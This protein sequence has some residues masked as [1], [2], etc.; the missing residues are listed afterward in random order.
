MSIGFTRER[1]IKKDWAKVEQIN[2][3]LERLESL[4]KSEIKRE[5]LLAQSKLVWKVEVFKQAII[6]RIVMLGAGCTEAW[7]ARNFLSAI[8]CMRATVETCAFIIDI[9]KQLQK[10]CKS[11]DFESINNLLAK[12]TFG[13]RQK[14]WLKNNENDIDIEAVQVLN[15]ID[16]LDKTF[17]KEK[18][19]VR[20]HYDA[21][22]D[23]CHPN[24]LGLLHSFGVIDKTTGTVTFS[25][26]VADQEHTL[27]HILAGMNLVL[28]AEVSVNNIEKLIPSILE[29]SNLQKLVVDSNI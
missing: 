9:E 25:D 5:G 13:T 6:H 2:K 7:N 17:D 22:S 26:S 28:F 27:N 15:C 20:T 11:S 1:A 29:I 16:N 10:L 4:K 23:F 12:I 19:Y 18:S 3:S 24:Y 14:S 21:S 8:L